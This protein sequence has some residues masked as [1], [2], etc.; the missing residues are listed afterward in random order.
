MKKIY[1]KNAREKQLLEEAYGAVYERRN[2][3]SGEWGGGLKGVFPGAEEGPDFDEEEEGK[4]FRLVGVGGMHSQ[5]EN[6]EGEFDTVDEVI[7]SIDLPEEY[8]TEWAEEIKDVSNWSS[9]GFEDGLRRFGIGEIYEVIDTQSADEYHPGY[10]KVEEE[11]DN[12]NWDEDKEVDE[13]GGGM[14]AKEF[15]TLNKTTPL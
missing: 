1:N 12:V 6:V 5:I 7:N 14:N 11:E 8:G 9:E 4:R 15:N 13:V 2:P 10:G 3:D